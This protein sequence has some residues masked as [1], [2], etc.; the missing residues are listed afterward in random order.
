MHKE[1]REI[2]PRTTLSGLLVF[3]VLAFWGYAL[4][5]RWDALTR[6]PWRVGWTDLLAA[7]GLLLVQMLVLATAWWYILTRLVGPL[8]WSTGASMW[9]RA[10][11]ARY[12]PGG[13][14]DVAG[15]AAL[16]RKAHIPLRAVPAG[17][18]LEIALQVE[19]AAL[20]LLL[21]LFFFPSP[22][23]R[24]Y[25]PFLGV[26]MLLF[27]FL[28]APPLFGRGLALI[29]RLLKRPNLPL[30][31][32]FSDL[33]VLLGLYLTAHLM[34][35]LGFVFFTRGLTDVGN[36]DIPVLVSSYIGAWLIGYVAIFA[37]AGVGVR[38]G[39]LLLLLENRFPFALVTGA[40][41]GYRV[42]LSLR[43]VLAALVGVRL[44]WEPRGKPGDDDLGG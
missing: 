29:F 17:A 7:Q 38:E 16:S 14:W 21:T 18:V 1:R 13:I 6:Y 36:A 3:L 40:A 19:A 32:T 8:S 35:G 34:Q 39:A 2:R 42:W 15:R 27:S 25:L 24:P 9:L 20:F 22:R 31:L 28:L 44:Q 11:L 33:L 43:D 12:V 10:Q 37:P 5:S 4:W 30:R 26:G 23:L 41:L